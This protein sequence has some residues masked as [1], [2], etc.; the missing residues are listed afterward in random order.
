M[1]TIG[2]PECSRLLTISVWETITILER[3]LT[4][5]DMLSKWTYYYTDIQPER[6]WYS[7][8]IITSRKKQV[9]GTESDIATLR[10]ILLD[11][12]NFELN[13][14]LH[15]LKT[16]PKDALF[17]WEDLGGSYWII[18]IHEVIAQILCIP[19]PYRN[20]SNEKIEEIISLHIW[21]Q[22][23]EDGTKVSLNKLIEPVDEWIVWKIARVSTVVAG[24]IAGIGNMMRQ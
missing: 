3:T 8:K 18:R 4:D 5:P 10:K 6:F 19:D 13:G 24:L 23:L 7:R 11:R 2:S 9:G 22:I 15:Y 21:H 14:L 20:L 1:N 17:D 16:L 12:F